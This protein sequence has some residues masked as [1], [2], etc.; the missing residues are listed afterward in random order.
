MLQIFIDSREVVSVPDTAKRFK[1]SVKTIYEWLKTGELE[2]LTH[3]TRRYIV[4]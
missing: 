4:L 2:S 1:V 3:K